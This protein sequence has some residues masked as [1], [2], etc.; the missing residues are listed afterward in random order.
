[1]TTRVAIIEDDA[2]ICEELRDF[3][4][5]TADISCVCTCRNLQTALQ[6]VPALAPDVIIMD[7]H[8][9]DG[10]GLDGASRLKQLLPET[11]IVMYTIYED[12]EQIFR[13]LKA[14]A[15][16]YLLKSAPP[17]EILRAIRE[18]RR[19]EVPMS[20]EVARKV[21]QSFRE[22]APP[23]IAAA[24]VAAEVEPLTKREEEVLELLAEG[25]SSVE[26]SRRLEIGLTTVH[27]HLKHIYGKLHVRSRT[28]AV[29]KY[30][31]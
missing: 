11:Q 15:S 29:I 7:I 2:E 1:M 20:G 18:V 31:G 19:G 3:L 16:G 17:P 8:L 5:E 24:A 28:E 6:K 21:I 4:A 23:R 27:S 9:P 26:I 13:A 14:G 25:L 22:P 30:L 12:A 10:S